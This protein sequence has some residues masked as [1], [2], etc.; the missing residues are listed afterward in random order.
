MHLFAY[1]QRSLF[2]LALI[3]YDVCSTTLVFTVAIYVFHKVYIIVLVLLYTHLYILFLSIYN[4]NLLG[5]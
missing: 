4:L 1:V 2:F 3:G 5:M